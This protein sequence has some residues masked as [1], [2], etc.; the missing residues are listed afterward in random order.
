MTSVCEPSCI[1]LRAEGSG[2]A[3]RVRS[4]TTRLF[5]RTLRSLS[6]RCRCACLSSHSR[7]CREACAPSA[8]TTH[9]SAIGMRVKYGLKTRITASTNTSTEMPSNAPTRILRR[10]A[11][12][13]RRSRT[14][15]TYSRARHSVWRSH[16]RPF[17]L[18][19]PRIRESGAIALIYE[20]KRGRVPVGLVFDHL[21]HAL[22]RPSGQ[23]RHHED[24]DDHHQNNG[25]ERLVIHSS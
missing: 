25:A 20:M 23:P 9:M 16:G 5:S 7:A 1:C 10:R 6:S 14:C 21:L 13:R 22:N 17:Q 18:D 2:C 24:G 11:A 4:S 8:S 3:A 15:A 12:A 19:S